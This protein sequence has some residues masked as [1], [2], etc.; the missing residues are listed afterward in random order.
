MYWVSGLDL[1]SLLKSWVLFY[2]KILSNLI[3]FPGSWGPGF[4]KG[5]EVLGRKRSVPCGPLLY[6]KRMTAHSP[7]PLHPLLAHSKKVSV[8]FNPAANK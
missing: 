7:S 2:S 8:T 3:W 4:T 5:D 1:T 6:E